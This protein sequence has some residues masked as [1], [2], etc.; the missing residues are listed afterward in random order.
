M[1]NGVQMGYH[2]VDDLPKVALSGQKKSKSPDNHIKQ[3][4]GEND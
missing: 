4:R 3:V 1:P 2:G